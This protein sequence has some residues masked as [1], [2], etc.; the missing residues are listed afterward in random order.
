MRNDLPA[1]T[2]TFLFTDVKGSTRLLHELGAE[3]YAAAL[4][5]HRR[6]IREACATEGGVE[7]D[8]QGDAFFFAFP[9]APGALA[10]AAV[11]T[12]SL[13]QGPI[14]VRVGLHTGTPFVTEVGYTG[15]D[16][17]TA[18]RIAASAHGGQVVLSSATRELLGDRFPLVA[19]G[20]HRFKDI[21]PAVVH[22][23]GRAI[24]PPLKTIWNTNLPRPASSFVGREAELT[25]VVARV[26]DGA[27]LLT[28][29]GPA[30]SG[31]TRLAIEAAASLVPEFPAGVFWVGLAPLARRHSSPTRSPSRSA[32]RTVSRSMSASGSSSSSSTTSS[33]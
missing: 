31:K 23:L 20:E 9:T 30:G 13:T 18:A 33:T 21:E 2:V 10:A 19:L 1:G 16:V 12:D 11:F 7:V 22:Q 28:L 6:A 26:A 29:T 24:F 25:D 17:V 32:P 5:E 3:G 27:R 4:A 14:Q 15:R 8:T